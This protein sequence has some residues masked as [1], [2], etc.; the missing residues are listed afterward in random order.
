MGLAVEV[1]PIGAGRARMGVWGKGGV[2]LLVP[3]LWLLHQSGQERSRSSP[4]GLAC[5]GMHVNT[6]TF[7]SILC[8]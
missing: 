6:G 5:V 3:P 2:G 8:A 7:S 1:A 4:Q